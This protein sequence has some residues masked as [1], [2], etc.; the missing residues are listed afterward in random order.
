MTAHYGSGATRSSQRVAQQDR[1]K[2]E[3][4]SPSPWFGKRQLNGKEG[5]RYGTYAFRSQPCASL[6][7]WRNNA[8]PSTR[9]FETHP[10]CRPLP[11]DVN[12]RRAGRRLPFPVHGRVWRRTAAHFPSSP[13]MHI[14]LGQA[15]NKAEALQARPYLFSLAA[16]CPSPEGGGQASPI[17]ITSSRRRGPAQVDYTSNTRPG[18][19]TAPTCCTR[20]FMGTARRTGQA[21]AKSRRPTSCGESFRAARAFS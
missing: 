9:L 3:P 1:A 5:L 2:C 14:N 13:S 19:R 17:H 11:C 7:H 10:R 21:P 16:G 6:V 18:G 20:P 8:P 4:S 15:S 12:G